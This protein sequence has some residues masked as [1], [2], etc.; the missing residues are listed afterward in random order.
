MNL[1]KLTEEDRPAID[2]AI[3]NDQF[4]SGRGD[5]SFF[6]EPC[7]ESFVISDDTGDVL[8]VRLARALRVNIVFADP[9]A[10]ERNKTAM[11][12]LALFLQKSAAESG[13]KEVVFTSANPRLRKFGTTV[14]FEEQPTLVMAVEPS[15]PVGSEGSRE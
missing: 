5:S 10:H 1:R 14:G 8:N 12:D 13:H 6:F 3:K 7:T 11:A 9:D 4:H 15:V 2:E